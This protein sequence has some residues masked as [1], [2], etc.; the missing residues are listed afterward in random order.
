MKPKETATYQRTKVLQGA[1]RE[2]PPR[3]GG[4]MPMSRFTIDPSPCP[5]L[6]SAPSS[7]DVPVINRGIEAPGEVA[8]WSNVRDWKSRV[9]ARV[10]RV[11]IPPSPPLRL[12][13]NGGLCTAK[14]RSRSRK[15]CLQ[16]DRPKRGALH[17]PAVFLSKASAEIALHLK[18]R[19]FD[20][21]TR[22]S[23]SSEPISHELGFIT[24]ATFGR[25]S[26]RRRAL[27]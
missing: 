13:R 18:Q 8:E 17:S 2:K 12:R 5:T 15:G 19:G 10:P 26:A 16:K 14:R 11:R 9:P 1:F 21:S 24:G 27:R 7:R 3:E 23:W 20:R 4:L 25:V 6:K 22:S